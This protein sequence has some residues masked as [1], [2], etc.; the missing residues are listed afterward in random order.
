ML[1]PPQESGKLYGLEPP[2]S[3]SLHASG[4]GWPVAL[5]VFLIQFRQ[6]FAQNDRVAAISIPPLQHAA[7]LAE[8][9]V[10]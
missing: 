1:P 3:R 2:R 9:H 7:Y 4:G 5:I 10:L 6:D 8:R